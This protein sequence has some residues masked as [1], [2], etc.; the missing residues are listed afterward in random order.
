MTRIE[1]SIEIEAPVE[2]VFDY[3]ADWRNKSNWYVGVL[4]WRPTTEQTKGVG[5]RFVFK[6]KFMGMHPET[7]METR[8]FI[9]DQS[10][11]YASIRGIDLKRQVLFASLG[12]RTQITDISEYTLPLSILGGLVDT[13]SFRRRQERRAEQSLQNLKK[14][15]E[16]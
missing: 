14:L 13:L 10:I 11:E 4:D 5:A 12:D 16:H 7:E 6:T 8:T 2:E 9:H 15:T 3:V 1:R